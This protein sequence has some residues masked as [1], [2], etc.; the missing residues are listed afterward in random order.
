MIGSYMYCV[1][2]LL[3]LLGSG[4]GALFKRSVHHHLKIYPPENVWEIVE[5]E[6]FDLLRGV[7]I[8]FRAPASNY[9]EI[10]KIPLNMRRLVGGRFAG[11]NI[12]KFP[13]NRVLLAEIFSNSQKT[14]SRMQ[15]VMKTVLRFWAEFW[16]LALFTDWGQKLSQAKKSKAIP[17]LT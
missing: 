6:H 9:I 10:L 17:K 4:R 1:V 2:N 14:A 5:S 13:K 8:L 7:R 12:L 16:F 3:L 15:R 11:W